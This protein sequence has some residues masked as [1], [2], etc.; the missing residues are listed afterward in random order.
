[1]DSFHPHKLHQENTAVQPVFL[2]SRNV[3]FRLDEYFCDCVVMLPVLRL[4]PFS[5]LGSIQ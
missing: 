1:M 5:A 2:C 3:S 4:L